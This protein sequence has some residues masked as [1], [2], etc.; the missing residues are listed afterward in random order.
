MNTTSEPVTIFEPTSADINPDRGE[1]ILPRGGAVVLQFAPRA[2]SKADEVHA[3][4]A[5]HQA[6][7]AVPFMADVIE[8]ARRRKTDVRIQ[9]GSAVIY[10]V[11][12]GVMSVG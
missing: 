2:T 3:W 1:P 6:A 12:D 4:F 9:V 11:T 10:R 7:D 5:A 8:A